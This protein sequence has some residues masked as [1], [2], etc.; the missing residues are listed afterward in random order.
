MTL[1]KSPG[2]YC[3]LIMQGQGC[4]FCSLKKKS[5]EEKSYGYQQKDIAV[6][7]YHS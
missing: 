1:F 2:F 6:L 5:L 7:K 3:F 4:T